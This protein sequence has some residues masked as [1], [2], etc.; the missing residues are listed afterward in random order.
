MALTGAD[1]GA[2]A[3][4]ICHA[5][6]QSFVEQHESR[7]PIHSSDGCAV[8]EAIAKSCQGH[9][10]QDLQDF[11]EKD[12]KRLKLIQIEHDF[13]RFHFVFTSDCK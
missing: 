4:H 2:E 10:R 6:P 7:L 13:V 11:G 5:G 12:L 1:A 9:L 8:G 3:D